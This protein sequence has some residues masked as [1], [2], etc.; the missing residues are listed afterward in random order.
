MKDE[1][2]G[3]FL[4]RI[5]GICSEEIIRIWCNHK[6]SPYK[7]LGRPTIKKIENCED[8]RTIGRGSTLDFFFAPRDENGQ[9]D[10]S[11]GYVVEMKCEIQYEGYKYMKLECID[12]I[13]HHK[14]EAFKTFLDL[15]TNSKSYCIEVK[16][17]KGEKKLK[18]FIDIILVW[19][20]ITT[21]KVTLDEIK[22]HYGFKDIIS[23]ERA[24]NDLIGWKSKE[25]QRFI[26]EKKD[27]TNN[28]FNDLIK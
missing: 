22:K 7:N 24:I 16:P 3:A 1:K 12:Q 21:D 5:F 26:E 19:G 15:H 17:V 11:T 13:K 20:S 18:E 14:G 27:W 10:E 8:V 2:E 6:D 4:S 25:Y 23:V 9:V 28:M